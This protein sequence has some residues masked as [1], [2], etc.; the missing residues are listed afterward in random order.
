MGPG[1][2][3]R[4]AQLI[5]WPVLATHYACRGFYALRVQGFLLTNQPA[6]FPLEKLGL[7]FA[8]T[9]PQTPCLSSR[10]AYAAHGK[11]SFR[12]LPAPAAPEAT[13]SARCPQAPSSA[14]RAFRHP[15]ANPGLSVLP[16]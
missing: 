16:L 6:Q 13:R 10:D 2:G 14:Q 9:L 3:F 7:S 15:F 4:K 8:G 5:V 1:S 12:T 11:E